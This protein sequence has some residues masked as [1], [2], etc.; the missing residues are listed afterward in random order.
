[1][2]YIKY[3]VPTTIRRVGDFWYYID[4]EGWGR[5]VIE[6]LWHLPGYTAEY[7]RIVQLLAEHDHRRPRATRRA[8]RVKICRDITQLIQNGWVI[9]KKGQL[10]LNQAKFSNPGI[11]TLTED[12][13]PEPKI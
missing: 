3:A 4:R 11:P 6:K 7:W 10:S 12:Y 5:L 9:R 13:L 2:A 1:M 8:E